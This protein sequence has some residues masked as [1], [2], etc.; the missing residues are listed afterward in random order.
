[1][2]IMEEMEGEEGED[3]TNPLHLGIHLEAISLL[4][5]ITGKE[6]GGGGAKGGEVDQVTSSG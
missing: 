2:E 4:D 6:K 1:M 3:E 5:L